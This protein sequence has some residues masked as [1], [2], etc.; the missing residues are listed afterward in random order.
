MADLKFY[1]DTSAIVK[2]YWHEDGTGFVNELY[3]LERKRGSRLYTV[4]HAIAEIGSTAYRLHREGKL[5]YENASSIV[6]LFLRESLEALCFVETDDDLYTRAI[7]TLSK[8][9][10]RAGDAIHLAAAL[11]LHSIYGQDLH[12]VSDD[13]RQCEAAATEGLSLLKP[14]ETESVK[15]LKLL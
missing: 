5:S 1:L 9:P 12:F 10:L 15:Y 3:G 2:R 14:R 4:K 7:V 13:A 8:Y 6:V 11:Y